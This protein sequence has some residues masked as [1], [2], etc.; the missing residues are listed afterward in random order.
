MEHI[1][2]NIKVAARFILM[3]LQRTLTDIRMHEAPEG[4]NQRKP[5]ANNPAGT[6]FTSLTTQL[7]QGLSTMALHLPVVLYNAGLTKTVIPASHLC[8]QLQNN[9]LE[10][11]VQDVGTFV[12]D[13]QRSNMVTFTRPGLPA[14]KTTDILSRYQRYTLA[15]FSN[16][17]NRDFSY[18]KDKAADAIQKKP[19]K[20]QK[21]LAAVNHKQFNHFSKAQEIHKGLPASYTSHF[22]D[23]P[24]DASGQP[25]RY[26]IYMHTEDINGGDIDF[27]NT[28]VIKINPKD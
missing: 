16:L 15:D 8:C 19:N 9:L 10:V 2:E 5:P 17:V 24:R 1:P 27:K 18:G 26:F 23:N 14:A 22:D 13:I 20:F 3:A 7:H 4:R 21:A 6:R 28:G 12:L 11:Q 25:S